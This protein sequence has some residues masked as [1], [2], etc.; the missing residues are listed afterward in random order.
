MNHTLETLE[1]EANRPEAPAVHEDA[2]D[3]QLAHFLPYQLSIASNAVSALIA[4]RYRSR[5][6]LKVTEWRVMAVLGDAVA[7]QEGVTQRDFTEISLMDKVAVNRACKVLDQRGLI[8]RAPN[9]S[10]G[11]SHLMVL[12]DEG[13]A[14]HR[15]VLP[16]AL[17]TES[18]MLSGF[19]AA[20]QRSL[21]AMLER[22]R[23]KA[24]HVARTPVCAQPN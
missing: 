6:G 13:R 9:S 22:L 14:V 5:F 12:T 3:V 4:E 21:R 16:L 2:R 17:E 24:E 20:E 15:E 19:S 23:R 7:D 1:A 8:A 18:E 11:R 10:D